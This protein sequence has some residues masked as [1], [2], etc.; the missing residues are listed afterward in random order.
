ML[1][2]EDSKKKKLVSFLRY[3]FFYIDYLYFY[4]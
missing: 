1:I 3:S 4:F 2:S